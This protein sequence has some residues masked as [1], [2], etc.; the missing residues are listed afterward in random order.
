[1]A[2]VPNSGSSAPPP[3]PVW[4]AT[5]AGTTPVGYGGFWIRV[6][7][8]IIDAILVS[9]V[10]G[11]VTAVFGI[12]YMDFEH[13]ENFDPTVNLLSLLV[14]WLYFALMESSER[15]AT[16]GKMAMGLRVVSNDGKRISFL[17]ATG[18]YFAKILSGMIFC[19]GY[20]MVAFT[21]RKRGLH[22]ML[23][24]TLVIKTR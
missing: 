3:P 18:R 12:K 2:S 19:I 17:N 14:F 7:A 5:P 9:I 6:V 11:V 13:P 4:D 16:V 22:D 1:M 8:Y 21:D 24:S 23:A 15:G 10:L 20:I